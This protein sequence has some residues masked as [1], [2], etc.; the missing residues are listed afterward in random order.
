MVVAPQNS[1]I[2]NDD[3]IKNDTSDTAMAG[4]DFIVENKDYV[5][6]LH[7]GIYGWFACKFYR[8]TS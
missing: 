1:D 7:S 6:K 3:A 2:E 5:E 8:N 4:L